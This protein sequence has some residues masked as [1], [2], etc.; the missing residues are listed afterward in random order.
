[1]NWLMDAEV[2]IQQVLVNVLTALVRA[3]N[4]KYVESSCGHTPRLDHFDWHHS[5]L[6]PATIIIPGHAHPK[7]Y[8]SALPC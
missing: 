5:Y 1:M 3:V 7:W 8:P 6:R 2:D 4:D